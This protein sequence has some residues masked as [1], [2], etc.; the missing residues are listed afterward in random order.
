MSESRKKLMML[1]IKCQE[2]ET[3]VKLDIS[4]DELTRLAIDILA[5]KPP[6]YRQAREEAAKLNEE[7]RAK[8][9]KEADFKAKYGIDIKGVL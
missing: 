2:T 1:V 8:R 4:K 5:E 9:A 6:T 7:K 3:G